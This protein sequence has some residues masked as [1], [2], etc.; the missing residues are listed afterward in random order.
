MIT[1]YD[2]DD[3]CEFSINYFENIDSIEP[4]NINLNKL[5]GKVKSIHIFDDSITYHV[6]IPYF[7]VTIKGNKHYPDS[8]IHIEEEDFKIIK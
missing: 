8:T 5:V 6:S 7:Q 4:S 2:I 1:K 3:S